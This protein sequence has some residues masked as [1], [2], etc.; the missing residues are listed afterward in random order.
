MPNNDDKDKNNKSQT[1]DDSEAATE[2]SKESSE[3]ESSSEYESSKGGLVFEAA[4]K[5]FTVGVSAAFMTEESI[6]NY[7]GDVKLPKDIMQLILQT[8]GRGKEELMNRV[9]KEISGIIQK[10]D[11]PKEVAKFLENH[12]IKITAEVEILPPKKSKTEPDEGQ[13]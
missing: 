1:G 6:R 10:T 8:A 13:A 4:K 7:L 5:L 12:R 9:S 3:S 11:L 2:Q